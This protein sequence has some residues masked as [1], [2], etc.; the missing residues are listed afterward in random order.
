MSTLA[1]PPS[2]SL[3]RRL[4]LQTHQRAGGWIDAAPYSARSRRVPWRPLPRGGHRAIRKREGFRPR[5]PADPDGRCSRHRP[6]PGRARPPN[7]SRLAD[8]TRTGSSR[9]QFSG[10]ASATPFPVRPSLA[11]DPFTAPPAC[12]SEPTQEPS[13]TSQCR[14]SL[15][16]TPAAAPHSAL[17]SMFSNI[18][19]HSIR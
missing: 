12:A 2:I 10:L 11:R 18:C 13:N 7:A 1:G 6:A 16:T 4:Q 9:R 8:S 5:P 14:G 3:P 19:T 15:K 17:R